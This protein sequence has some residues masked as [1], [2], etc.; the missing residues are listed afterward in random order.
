[1]LE[2]DDPKDRP[3]DLDMAAVLELMVLIMVWGNRLFLRS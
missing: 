2:L 3:I 1:V